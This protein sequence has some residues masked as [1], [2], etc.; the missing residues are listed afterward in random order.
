MQVKQTRQECYAFYL[1][2]LERYQY[3]LNESQNLLKQSF[4]DFANLVDLEISLNKMECGSFGK[5]V[6]KPLTNTDWNELQNCLKCLDNK[7]KIIFVNCQSLI[8]KNDTW[9]LHIKKDTDDQWCRIFLQSDPTQYTEFDYPSNLPLH[10]IEAFHGCKKFTL[11]NKFDSM[12]G[13]EL[14]SLFF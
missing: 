14:F 12:Q 2:I 6:P 1:D 13:G 11:K 4:T 3:H 10:I 5:N 8:T 9:I 7:K